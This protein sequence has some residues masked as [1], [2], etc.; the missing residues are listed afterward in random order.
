MVYYQAIKIAF[1]AST[2]FAACAVLASLV[3]NAKG[4]ERDPAKKALFDG[5]DAEV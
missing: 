5:E 2:V 1:L 3:A 4:L